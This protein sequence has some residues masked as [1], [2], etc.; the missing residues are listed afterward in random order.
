[1]WGSTVEA[2]LKAAFELIGLSEDPSPQDFVWSYTM[3]WSRL[4]E[5]PAEEGGEEGHMEEGLLP[6]IDCCNHG[7]AG[8]PVP[9]FYES[10]DPESQSGQRTHRLRA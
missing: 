4:L 10:Q 6:F 7:E 5:W 9:Q 2:I 1:M 8:P 3:V